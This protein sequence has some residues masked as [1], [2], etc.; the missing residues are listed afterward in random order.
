[1]AA[2]VAA[3]ALAITFYVR[4]WA[5]SGSASQG[6]TFVT[7][8]AQQQTITLDD[9]SVVSLGARTEVHAQLGAAERLIVLNRGE[10]WFKVARD[11]QRPFKVFAGD[12]VITALGTEFNV[13]DGDLDQVTV[14]VGDG[15]VK[16]DSGSRGERGP[17]REQLASRVSQWES[18]KL[19]KGQEVTYDSAGVRGEVQRADV[20]AAIAW[21]H[22]RLEY[23]HQPLKAVIA[24]VNRYSEKPIVLA[25]DA[26]GEL[27]FSG[28]V[29]EGQIEEWIRALE[30]A[31][32]IAVT[33]THDRILLRSELR[34]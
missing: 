23:V 10:A 19:I 9:G 34:P 13:L 26:V 33:T 30:S 18:A 14:T 27:D 16:V 2:G 7:Q 3:I 32:P 4:P 12:G 24:R 25:D 17:A 6:R 20:E 21:K 1:M 28:T 22:G 8:R 15:A 29:F 5:G 31:F 11:A